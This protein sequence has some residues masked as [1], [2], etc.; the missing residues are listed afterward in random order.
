MAENIDQYKGTLTTSIVVA[1]EVVMPD[2]L[3]SGLNSTINNTQN[4]LKTLF[5]RTPSYTGGEVTSKNG[6]ITV[7]PIIGID[8]SNLIFCNS[9]PT[10][11]NLSDESQL[12]APTK[13]GTYYIQVHALLKEFDTQQRAFKDFGT[14]LN[15][16]RDMATQKS[17][18]PLVTITQD[19]DASFITL[20][21]LTITDDK[22]TLTQ[23][24]ENR[25]KTLATITDLLDT[26]VDK[27][28]NILKEKIGLSQLKAEVSSGALPLGC[29][30]Q[31][32]IGTET[33]SPTNTTRTYYDAITN[34]LKMIYDTY[35]KDGAYTFKTPTKIVGN[36]GT[37]SLIVEDTTGDAKLTIADK[38]FIFHKNGTV[39]TPLVT[40][41]DD[42]D[43][44]QSH[45]LQEATQRIEDATHAELENHLANKT[46]DGFPLNTTNPHGTIPQDIAGLDDY[47]KSFVKNDATYLIYNVDN[48][49]L[50]STELLTIYS[51]GLSV[52]TSEVGSMDF[53]EVMRWEYDHDKKLP[54]L[55]MYDKTQQHRMVFTHKGLTAQK[56]T[57]NTDN[58]QG[59][60]WSDEGYYELDTNGNL[61]I[62]NGDKPVPS[63]ILDDTDVIYHLDHDFLGNDAAGKNPIGIAKLP[64]FNGYL[65]E[66]FDAPVSE[67]LFRGKATI[68]ATTTAR[69]LLFWNNAPITI[70]DK[71]IDIDTT[72][73]NIAGTFNNLAMTKGSEWGLENYTNKTRLAI[74]I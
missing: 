13:T 7:A 61:V 48:D 56:Y 41:L 36:A 16:F 9:K 3:Q 66:D 19:E 15:S 70:D 22:T 12:N 39:T 71:H 54:T 55:A 46:L 28:G 58:N 64:Q 59:D 34:V 25:L 68:N 72:T 35:L 4:T 44:V 6:L 45:H 42:T 50:N 21:T 31:K 2:D 62:T 29:N 49:P 51:T 63:I 40:T 17:L 11:T 14:G 8:S 27:D 69:D 10:T 23:S 67:R 60:F 65:F 20:A 38:S 5:S 32:I 1:E 30:P 74:T 53:K 24:T 57:K 37:L 47:I 33:Y 52:K 43:L 73:Q 26:L 18:L